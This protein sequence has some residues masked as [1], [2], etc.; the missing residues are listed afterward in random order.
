MTDD[1]HTFIRA[2]TADP[3]DDTIRLV[4]ADWLDEQGD[5]VHSSHA[6]F[7]RLQVRRSRTDPF[8]PER[9]ELVE[10][11][12][13]CLQMH[14]RAWNGRVHR[15]LIRSG[16][17]ERVDARRGAIREWGYHRGMIAHVSVGAQALVTHADSVFAL[18][19][20]QRVRLANWWD[21][22]WQRDAVRLSPFVS[23]LKVVAPVGAYVRSLRDLD[24]LAPFA[25]VPVLD[26][27][28]VVIGFRPTELLARARAGGT[29][30]VV[31]FH[32]S[33]GVARSV[34]GSYGYRPL[35]SHT[36]IHVIDPHGKW[37]A[38]RFGFA[39]LTGEVFTPIPYQAASR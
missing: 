13:A 7:V 23:R 14:K 1:E 30:P 39:D 29:S 31:L 38:L 2:A 25:A 24:S 22:D 20:I 27:R 4:Y 34:W 32:W 37:D 9:A 26:L 10:Q 11:E 35:E 17:T 21:A 5:E 3:D 8:D 33:V 16:F 28:S 36:K 18:G 6:A 12:V 19:P 15:F